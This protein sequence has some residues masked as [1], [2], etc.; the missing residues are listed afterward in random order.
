MIAKACPSDSL[1]N[2]FFEICG[3]IKWQGK[4]CSNI[5][6]QREQRKRPDKLQMD[7]E[8]IGQG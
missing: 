2:I 3:C 1:L 8:V 6:I 7:L 5:S 4:E